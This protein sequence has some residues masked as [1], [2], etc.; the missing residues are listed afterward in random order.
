MSLKE[1]GRDWAKTFARKHVP[2]NCKQYKHLV[3]DVGTPGTNMLGLRCDSAPVEGKLVEQDEDLIAVKVGRNVFHIFPKAQLDNP[4]VVT[5]STVRITPYARRSFDGLRL[6]APRDINEVMSD[7]STYTCQ[8]FTIGEAVSYLPVDKEALQSSYLKD[9]ITQIEIIPAGDG[10]RKLS[11][12]LIDA[13]ASH[14]AVTYEDP[15]DSDPI[16]VRPAL[17]FVINT[18]KHQGYFT[19]EYN[20]AIDYYDLKLTDKEGNVIKVIEDVDCVEQ[21]APAIVDLVDDGSWRFAKVELLKPA[22]KQ[23]EAA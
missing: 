3:H 6:D 8:R 23:K 18:A 10:I 1:K 22:P 20:R 2:S 13:G 4:T 14:G 19:I 21:L 5:G 9:M 12:V 16:S 11:Q 15:P 17:H 7:G